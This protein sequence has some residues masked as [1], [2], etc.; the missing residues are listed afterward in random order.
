MWK[1]VT[2][3]VPDEGLKGIPIKSYFPMEKMYNLY[4]CSFVLVYALELLSPLCYSHVLLFFLSKIEF[5]FADCYISGVDIIK[6]KLNSPI[7]LI[8]KIN[9]KMS[10]FSSQYVSN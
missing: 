4:Y 8:V 2:K 5:Q 10:Y 7:T 1:A 9:R 3:D 6:Q